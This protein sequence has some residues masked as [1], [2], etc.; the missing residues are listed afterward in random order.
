M[1]DKAQLEK[2]TCRKKGAY[3][4]EKRIKAVEP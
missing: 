2:G 4:A 1:I 3:M